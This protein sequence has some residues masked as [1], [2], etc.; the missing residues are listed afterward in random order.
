MAVIQKSMYSVRR[1]RNWS[2]LFQCCACIH[3]AAGLYENY[4]GHTKKNQGGCLHQLI[5]IVIVQDASCSDPC[6]LPFMS[7]LYATPKVLL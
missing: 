4:G 7:L 2:E 3:T 6:M 1:P 5:I